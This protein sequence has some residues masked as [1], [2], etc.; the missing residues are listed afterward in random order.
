MGVTRKKTHSMIVAIFK[1]FGTTGRILDAPAGSG[2]ITKE[3]MDA[4]FQVDAADIDPE[5]FELEGIT[6]TKVDLNHDLPYEDGLFDYILCSNGIEH[7]EDQYTFIRECYRILKPNGKVLITTP[8][9]LNLKSR[10]ANLLTGFPCFN[11]RPQNEVDDFAGGQ[12]I[13]MANYFD[14]RVNLHRNGFKIISV[15]TNTYT[16]TGMFFF[17]LVPFIYL[18][19]YSGFRREKDSEQKERNKEMLRHVLSADLLYGKKLFVLAEKDS[20]FLRKT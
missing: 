14:L 15:R 16:T 9:L 18:L 7:L 6:C 10:V 5:L 3:L 13:N 4:G 19:T 2:T 1:E 17:F 20:R 12:H 11:D 8:N